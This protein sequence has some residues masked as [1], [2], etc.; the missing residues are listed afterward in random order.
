MPGGLLS[1]LAL[2]FFSMFVGGGWFLLKCLVLSKLAIN[3]VFQKD[4]FGAV[5]PPVEEA[6]SDVALGLN[7]NNWV[8]SDVSSLDLLSLLTYLCAGVVLR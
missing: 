4:V 6:Y 1:S 2:P 5:Y 7:Q 3:W 8:P